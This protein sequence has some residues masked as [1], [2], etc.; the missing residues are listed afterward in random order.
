[1]GNVQYHSN[2]A[3]YPGYFNSGSGVDFEPLIELASLV[4]HPHQHLRPVLDEVDQLTDKEVLYDLHRVSGLSVVLNA[5]GELTSPR[6]SSD[7]D[8]V[9]SPSLFARSLQAGRA[10][11]LGICADMF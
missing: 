9:M 7:C 4:D 10:R 3:R 5:D 11:S 1:V 6:R 2:M 8:R